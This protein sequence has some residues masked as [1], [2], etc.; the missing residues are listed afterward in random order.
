M[1]LERWILAILILVVAGIQY[2]LAIYALR[3][4]SRRPTV[5]YNNKVAWA[6]LVL[7]LP[8]VGA[9][10]YAVWGPTSFLPRPNRPPRA[11]VTKLEEGDL[12]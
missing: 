6:L 1:T 3:D 11:A 4:L 12:N 7:A 8:F 5:R 2:G 10:V 9:F